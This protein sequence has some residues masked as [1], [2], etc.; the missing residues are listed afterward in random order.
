M[1]RISKRMINIF[2]LRLTQLCSGKY[3]HIHCLGIT[4]IRSQI[5]YKIKDKKMSKR[6]TIA[7][8]NS[9]E[10]YTWQDIFDNNKYRNC[11]GYFEMG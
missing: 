3:K 7:Y 6:W 4:T 5:S 10:S 1:Q 8:Q 9:S 2:G 11:V